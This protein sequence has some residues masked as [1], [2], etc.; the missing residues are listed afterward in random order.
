MHLLG[1]PGVAEELYRSAQRLRVF[2]A[3][4]VDVSLRTV[5]ELVTRP[6]GE[7]KDRLDGD[8]LLGVG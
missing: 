3:R 2:V 4:P 1:L 6:P 5:M 7:M 8:V